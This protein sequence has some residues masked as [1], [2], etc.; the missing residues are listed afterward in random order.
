MKLD[1]I[2]FYTLSDQRVKNVSGISPLWR[3]ELLITSKCNFKC[4]YC[5]RTDSKAD[6]SLQEAVYIVDQWLSHDLKNIRFSGGEPTLVDWLPN[7]VSHCK[8]NHVKHIAISS[9]GSADQT[10]YENL[11]RCGVNDFSIS[12]D[13]CCASIGDMMAGNI[14]GIWDKIVSN[15]KFLASKT[16]VTVG[17]V[18]TKETVNDVN[19]II[20]YASDE[21]GVADIRIISSAQWNGLIDNIDINQKYLDKYPILKYRWKNI[22]NNKNVRGLNK[23]DCHTCMLMF[24]D[25]AVVGDEHFPCI[26]HLREGGKP[27]GKVGNDMRAQRIAYAVSHDTH[28]DI[29][30]K[31]NCLDVCIDYNN[32]YYELNDKG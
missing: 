1:D 30:C 29:I 4:S 32:R 12:L 5:R 2:G 17:I 20:K 27:I 9:N 28:N 3:C 24:D 18:L 21:L 7:I 31:N 14:T 13:A 26:I 16:Y 10:V 23:N 19:N 25:V 6:I 11:L 22:K 15:I 8:K